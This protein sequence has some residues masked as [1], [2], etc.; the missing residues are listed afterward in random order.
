MLR[1]V[2]AASGGR[3]YPLPASRRIPGDILATLR[4]EMVREETRLWNAPLLVLLFIGLVGTE[5]W[6]RKRNHLL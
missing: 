4:D 6:I 2:A 5:W 3:Y 1:D